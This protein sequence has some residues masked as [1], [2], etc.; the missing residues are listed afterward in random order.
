MTHYYPAT[1]RAPRFGLRRQLHTLSVDNRL[2][3]ENSEV[4]EAE[5]A[6]KEQKGLSC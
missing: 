2:L 5:F 4:E 3:R 6:G 1:E